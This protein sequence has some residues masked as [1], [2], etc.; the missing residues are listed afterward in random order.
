MPLRSRRH[1]GRTG[2]RSR[3]DGTGVGDCDGFG[4]AHIRIL[5]ANDLGS[6]GSLQVTSLK[7]YVIWIVG[8]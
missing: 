8:S 1:D 3:S 6:R 5:H 7:R 2:T 4:M